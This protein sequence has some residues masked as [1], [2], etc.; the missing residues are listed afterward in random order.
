MIADIGTAK[1]IPDIPQIYPQ[2]SNDNKMTT[3]CR[4]RFSPSNLGST[5]FPIMNCTA[6][7]KDMSKIAGKLNPNLRKTTGK[8]NTTANIEP[9]FGMKFRKNVAADNKNAASIPKIIRMINEMIPVRR[10]VKNLVAI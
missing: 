9:I 3:G 4:P 8:A 10:D 1:N 6:A 2:N 5:T 7:N